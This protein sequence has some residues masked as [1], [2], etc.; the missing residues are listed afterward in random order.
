MIRYGSQDVRVRIL[1]VKYLAT[2]IETERLR[3][4]NRNRKAKQSKS[5]KTAF[6]YFNKDK[7]QSLKSSSTNTAYEALVNHSL[8]RLDL[9][10]RL[11][12]VVVDD[13][14]NHGAKRVL[15]YGVRAPVFFGNLREQTGENCFPRR[16]T[17]SLFCS[18][19]TDI[20]EHLRKP[21]GGYWRM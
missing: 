17:G 7:T 9:R 16:P 19:C 12:T 8:Y 1:Q 5:I 11:P 2:E 18:Y 6:P 21:P 3:N 4:R 20:F 14:H 10:R 15:E 13:V